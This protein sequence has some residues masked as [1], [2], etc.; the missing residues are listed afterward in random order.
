MSEDLRK[1]LEEQ[2]LWPLA[3]ADWTWEMSGF[4]CHSH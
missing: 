1:A 3:D 4:L 2:G